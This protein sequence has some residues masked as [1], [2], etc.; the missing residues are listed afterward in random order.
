MTKLQRNKDMIED[1]QQLAESDAEWR[2]A[3]QISTETII[4]VLQGRTCTREQAKV[5]LD[6]IGEQI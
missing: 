3:N 4:E 2:L 1:R 5:V 6:W